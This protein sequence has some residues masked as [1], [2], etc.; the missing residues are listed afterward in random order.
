MG[1]EQRLKPCLLARRHRAHRDF[2]K[3]Q[4]LNSPGCLS[5]AMDTGLG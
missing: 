3:I 4:V 5:G 2:T 1:V